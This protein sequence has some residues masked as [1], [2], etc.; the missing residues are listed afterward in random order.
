VLCGL[1]RSAQIVQMGATVTEIVTAAAL[2][3]L[4]AA[5]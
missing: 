3:A 5:A 2:A 1:A 4:G